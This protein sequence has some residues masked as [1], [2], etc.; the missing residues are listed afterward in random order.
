MIQLTAEIGGFGLKVI[1]SRIK[2][3]LT[4]PGFLLEIALDQTW[5]SAGKS[6]GESTQHQN[7]RSGDEFSRNEFSSTVHCLIAIHRLCEYSKAG[8]SHRFISKL[9]THCATP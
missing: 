8:F 9:H 2:T 4:P 1:K 3:T 6:R 5:Q 7:D